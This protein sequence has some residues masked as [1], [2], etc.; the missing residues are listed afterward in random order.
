MR[1]MIVFTD[2]SVV[3]VW[4]FFFFKQ[5]TAYEIV[6]GDWSSDVCSSDLA[7][8]AFQAGL[9]HRPLRRVDHDRDPG[10]L[11]LGRDEVEE[12]DHRRLRIEQ[13]RVHVHVEQVGA[14]ANLVEGH[15]H[16]PREITRLDEAAEA[17]GTRDVGALAD[18]HEAAL[19]AD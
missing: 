17:R 6:S 11:R 19:G 15:C 7:L 4:F 18:G 3:I 10:D 16:R 1:E 8:E 5:K 2:Y 9:E 13:V 14:A 12:P